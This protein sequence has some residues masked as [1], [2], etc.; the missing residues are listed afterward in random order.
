MFLKVSKYVIYVKYK[1]AIGQ[2]LRPSLELNLHIFKKK[3]WKTFKTQITH[4]SICIN[5]K[6]SYF[7]VLVEWTQFSHMW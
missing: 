5:I 7:W 6:Y 2:M 1:V 4:I 3:T